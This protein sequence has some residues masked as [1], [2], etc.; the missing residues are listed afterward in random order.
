MAKLL[1]S[2]EA[3]VAATDVREWAPPAP[4]PACLCWGHQPRSDFG[5]TLTRDPPRVVRGLPI[6][7]YGPSQ[8]QALAKWIESD[9]VPRTEDEVLSEMMAFL[10]YKRRGGRIVSAL[11]SAIRRARGH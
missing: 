7:E 9:G 5:S 2:H 11:T 10:G 3:A 8:L 6:T 4:P 1:A